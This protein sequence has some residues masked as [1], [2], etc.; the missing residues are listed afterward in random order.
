MST[1]KLSVGGAAVVLWVALLGVFAPSALAAAPEA[2]GPVTV[3][4]PVGA[5]KALLHGVLSPASEGHPGA[6]AFLYKKGSASCEGES[7][8]PESPG[9]MLGFEAE[10]VSQELTGLEPGTKYTVCL[11]AETKG[12]ATVGPA[13]TFTTARA[14]EAPTTTSPA[15]DVTATTATLL[16]ALNPGAV[17]EAGESYEFRYRASGTECE[18]EGEAATS[19]AAAT[20]AKG[21]EVEAKLTELQPN[22]QYTFCLLAV[23]ADEEIAVGAPVTFKTFSAPISIAE[24]TFSEVRAH[25]ATVSAQ[26]DLGNESGSYLFQYGTPAEFQGGTERATAETQVSAVEGS[27]SATE[28]LAG[29]EP[30]S[31]YEFQIVVTNASSETMTGGLETFDTMAA[32]T[33]GLPDGRVYEMVTPPDNQDADVYVP[34]APDTGSLSQGIETFW[35][36][37]AATDGDSVTYVAAPTFA[38]YGEGGKGLGNQYLARRSPS[39]EWQQ[40]VLQPP[41]RRKTAYQAFSSDLTTGVLDSGSFGEPNTPPLTSNAPALGYSVLYTRDDFMEVGIEEDLYQP[42]FT[43]SVAFN[44]SNEAFGIPGQVGFQGKRGQR[45]AFAGATSGFNEMFFEAND[46]LT[47]P[48][49]PPRPALDAR[50]KAEPHSEDD[51]L[52]DSVGEHDILVD[53]LPDGEVAGNATFGA[54]PLGVR[55]YNTPNFSGVVAPGGHWVY[56]TDLAA[57]PE[58]NRVFVR[59]NPGAPESP[60]DG[61]GECTIA[62]DACTVAVSTGPARYWTSAGE[63]R[64]VFYQESGQLLRYDALSKASEPWTQVS[65]GVLGL[66]GAGSDGGS[67]Y[68]VATGVLAGSGVSSQ[69]VPPV[70]GEPNL[71]LLR[72]GSLPM[73]I[74]TLTDDDGGGAEPMKSASVGNSGIAGGEFGDW[75]AGLGNRTDAVTADGLSAVFMSARSLPVVGF[76]HGYP[77]DGYEEIYSYQADSNELFCISCSATGEPSDAGSYLPVSWSAVHLPEWVADEGNRVFFDSNVP[78]LSQDTNGRQ[79]VY[80]WER[81]GTGS[82]SAGAHLN[83]GCIYLLSGGASEADS[84]FVAAS[85]SGDDVFIVTRAQLTKTDRNDAFDL[86]DARVGGVEPLPEPACTGAGCQGVPAPPPTFATPP[87]NTYAGI[88]NFPPP[89][90][91]KPTVKARKKSA[92]CKRGLV[93]KHDRCFKAK[94]KKRKTRKSN[95]RVK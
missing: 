45:P 46:D 87:S 31:E 75:Q 72:H 39:G 20:G 1:G 64:Y 58:E 83:G 34:Y 74:A 50:I 28:Q 79:D 95:R 22:R 14:L 62:T 37:Q 60:R 68:V 8:A 57:G 6:Y 19:R 80:E 47:S 26:I 81:A 76:P 90:P 67:V 69:G 94:A 43:N 10:E 56:W 11:R 9:L 86:Y 21:E 23:N 82:C 61:H 30:A 48:G 63:G 41:G 7:K 70:A 85:E 59:E 36:F 93:R 33:A 49:D 51:Y 78:L 53:V 4:S 55:E 92:K 71:Y 54:V 35:P 12:G 17:A 42:L 2:P 3:Q 25:S 38:G 15:G 13:V 88:G 27:V 73:F 52:Y 29:L 32:E 84:W 44:L 40:T 65:A 16:G 18:G 24:E 77:N 91:S 66:L 5:T 89:T